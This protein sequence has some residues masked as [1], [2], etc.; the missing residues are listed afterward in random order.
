MKS[1]NHL[2]KHICNK[3]PFVATYPLL[4]NRLTSVFYHIVS[5]E[6]LPYL[7][8]LYL[9]YD[10]KTF[11]ED[12]Y[13]FLSKFN[14]ISY[15]DLI[16]FTNNRGS[17]PKYPLFLSFDDG[18][19]E[20]YDIIAPILKEM[21][22][23]ATF[24]I[25][26]STINNKNMIFAHKKALCINKISQFNEKKFSQLLHVFSLKH[27][28]GNHDRSSFINFIKSQMN[29]K[30]TETL[31][32]NL[33]N[34]L[35][36]DIFSILRNDSPYLTN[37]QLKNLLHQGFNIGAHSHKHYKF[38]YLNDEER[39][40]EIFKS[41]LFLQKE[42]TLTDIGFSFPNSTQ[43]VSSSWMKA[44]MEKYKS[45]NLFF[46]TDGYTKND[47]FLINRI[48][49]EDPF[50]AEMESTSLRPTKILSQKYWQ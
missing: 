47:N 17:L 13:F 2:L 49:M 34:L 50:R 40:R 22:I 32:D 1:H 44:M 5:D 41:V 27:K 4:R 23:P 37:K 29:P 25:I 31:I 10:V 43:G 14:F 9:Y 7:N 35:E 11:K 45:I 48:C 42:L 46:G 36:I 16:A 18:H 24:F 38:Q 20:T 21:G 15:D 28:V 39:E 26:S 19:R 8:N 6:L 33:V 12:L 30:S 3:I